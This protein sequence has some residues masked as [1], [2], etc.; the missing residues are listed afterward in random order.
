MP[1]VISTG[2]AVTCVAEAST[3]RAPAPTPH[4]HHGDTASIPHRSTGPGECVSAL[5]GVA[6]EE[7]TWPHLA[8]AAP[9]VGGGCTGALG[10]KLPPLDRP[11]ASTSAG[12][13]SGGRGSGG[14]RRRPSSCGS[15]FTDHA[16]NSYALYCFGVVS[17]FLVICM[18][19]GYVRG[20][21]C[22]VG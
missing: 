13:F 7:A 15:T 3:L 19:A 1:P 10:I 16:P 8:A 21:G 20:D 6:P 12:G 9:G 5:C 22:A 11:D 2:R 17:E 4:H 14:Y 18:W